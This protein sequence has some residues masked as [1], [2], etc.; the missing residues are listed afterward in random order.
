MR[1]INKKNSS[2]LERRQQERSAKRNLDR[3]SSVRR[4]PKRPSRE[5]VSYNRRESRKKRKRKLSPSPKQ[6]PD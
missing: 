5:N 2:K 6:K 4:E 1:E 3:N